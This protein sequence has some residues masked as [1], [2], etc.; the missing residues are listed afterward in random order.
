MKRTLCKPALLSMHSE[1]R[2]VDCEIAEKRYYRAR[3]RLLRLFGA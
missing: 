2:R 3:T 1:D